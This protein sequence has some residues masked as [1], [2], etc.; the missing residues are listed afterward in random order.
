MHL[1]QVVQRLAYRRHLAIIQ[2]TL[3]VARCEAAGQQQ[4]VAARWAHAQRI[5][6][7]DQHAPACRGSAGLH[8]AEV[9][10]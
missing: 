6:Q 7:R 5:G 10:L 8:E 9:A 3:P 2:R 4:L 1:E